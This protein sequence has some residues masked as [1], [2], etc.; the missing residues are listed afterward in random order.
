M[1]FQ[2]TCFFTF[3]KA[4]TCSLEHIAHSYFMVGGKT[5]K[6]KRCYLHSFDG[7]GKMLLFGAQEGKSLVFFKHCAMNTHICSYT[8]MMK[9]ILIHPQFPLQNIS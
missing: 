6:E 9:C 7:W 8:E 4:S 1:Q 2:G 5:K 3:A